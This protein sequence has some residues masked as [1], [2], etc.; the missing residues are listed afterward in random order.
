M[1]GRLEEARDVN[2]TISLQ[3]DKIRQAFRE[4][5]PRQLGSVM[6]RCNLLSF[7]PNMMEAD[8]FNPPG[9]S[10]SAPG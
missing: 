6:T 8:L 10:T 4:S 9:W 3:A 1:E 2:L 7:F 5:D